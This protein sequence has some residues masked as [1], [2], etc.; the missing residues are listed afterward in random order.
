[1]L[2]K[3]EFGAIAIAS[4]ILAFITSLAAS[5]KA[6][7]DALIIFI[8]IILINT[9]SKKIA[10]HYFD[11]E[12]EIK[13]WELTRT[14]F[15]GA[16]TKGFPQ[17]PNHKF[18]NPFLIGIFLPIILMLLSLGI[19]KWLA[20]L[21]FEVKPKIYKA[22][23]RFGLYSFSEMT[24]NHI[25][26]IAAAGMLAN[27]LLAIVGYLIGFPLFTR[28][29]VYYVAFNLIPISNLDGNKI[30]FGNKTLYLFLLIIEF[31]ALGYAF[32]LY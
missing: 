2:N 22:A 27:L 13:I 23:K 29:S 7:I 30:F 18:K 1:M 19:I 17:N 10:S 16:L 12:A 3:K 32:L 4:V 5:Q 9:T 20:C 15:F 25:G 26:I 6:F 21:T 31:I 14:G 24:E 8:L 28:L 11:A